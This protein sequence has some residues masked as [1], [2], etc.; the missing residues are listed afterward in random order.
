M[1]GGAKEGVMASYRSTK[2]SSGF[3]VFPESKYND[4]YGHQAGDKMLTIVAGIMRKYFENDDIFR[5]G[6]DEFVVM[7]EDISM[8]EVLLK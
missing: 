5:I 2:S 6:G 7:C 4:Y 3:S 8:K 1:S